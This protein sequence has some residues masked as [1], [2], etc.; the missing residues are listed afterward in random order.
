MLTSTDSDLE[1][2]S[3]DDE[4]YLQIEAPKNYITLDN[5]DGEVTNVDNHTVAVNE[6][7]NLPEHQQQ[8]KNGD[9]LK[10]DKNET[11]RGACDYN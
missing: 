4:I 5:N 1:L 3:S 10:L 2:V 7:I 11:V 8:Q 9:H 6:M